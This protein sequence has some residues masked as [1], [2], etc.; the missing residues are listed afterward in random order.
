MHN[1][2]PAPQNAGAG[3][4]LSYRH[5]TP[6]TT[7]A[8]ITTTA[9]TTIT[10]KHH[11]RHP[12][13]HLHHL[14]LFDARP[15]QPR[16]T[17]PMNGPALRWPHRP[18][19]SHPP[20]TPPIRLTPTIPIPIKKGLPHPLDRDWRKA[21]VIVTSYGLP[22]PSGEQPWIYLQVTYR[23]CLSVGQLSLDKLA[24]KAGDVRD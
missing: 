6:N 9:T 15:V 2:S 11:H 23:Y 7:T 22:A 16:L 4:I 5:N 14:F 13:H 3:L 18:P 17:R 20:P 12:L 8:T 19:A 21:F 1:S 24:V 10:A